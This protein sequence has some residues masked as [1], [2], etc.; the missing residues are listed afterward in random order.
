MIVKYKWSPDSSEELAKGWI[1]KADTTRELALKIG[2]NPETLE[3]ALAASRV[4]ALPLKNP[5]PNV[6]LH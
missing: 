4:N 5:G 3:K 2:K 6:G 1:L